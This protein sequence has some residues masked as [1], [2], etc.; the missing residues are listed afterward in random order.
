MWQ[1]RRA[2]AVGRFLLTLERVNRKGKGKVK[3]K[4]MGTEREKKR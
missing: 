3:R 2:S 1:G 4:E